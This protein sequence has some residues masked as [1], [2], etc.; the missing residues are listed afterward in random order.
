MNGSVEMQY[1]FDTKYDFQ[2]FGFFE[3]GTVWNRDPTAANPARESLTSTGLGMRFG[4][5]FEVNGEVVAAKPLNRRVETEG[6]DD[7]RVFF[8]LNK[9]F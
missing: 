4:L 1:N 7:P 6:D 8:S 2:L 9:S 3:S 5:P